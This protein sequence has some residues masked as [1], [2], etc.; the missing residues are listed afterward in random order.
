MKKCI[1]YITQRYV[2]FLSV[3]VALGIA[4]GIVSSCR[5]GAARDR[6][7]VDR[8]RDGDR[9]RDRNV[10]SDRDDERSTRTSRAG[11]GSCEGDRDC[12]DKCEDLFTGS[13]DRGACED[14][15]VNEVEG[16]F[17][18]F[19]E[20]DGILARPKEDDLDDVHPDDIENAL[21]IDESLW[22]DLAKDYTRSQAKE[23]LYWIASDSDVF[24]AI[25]DSVDEDDQDDLFIDI[26]QE[27]D[28]SL[29]EALRT[30]LGDDD[31]ENFIYLADNSGNNS[32]V[33]YIH[34]LLIEGACLGSASQLSTAERNMYISITEEDFRGP[35][36]ALGEVYC[37]EVD[38]DYILENAF[39]TISDGDLEEFVEGGSSN[40]YTDGLGIDDRDSDDLEEVC[41]VVCGSGNNRIYAGSTRP[42]SC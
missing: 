42:G 34:D 31:E 17:N 2:L 39:T 15:T 24:E 3:L 29:T 5:G 6:A 37:L 7:I 22:S 9:D 32:A 11:G 4:L 23:V 28:D 38:D 26:F 27:V 8:S 40:S 41:N 16:M 33:N 25:S 13:R 30:K 35:A 19:E 10:R 21:K 1:K 18:A 14:L 12:E 36:C 20:D